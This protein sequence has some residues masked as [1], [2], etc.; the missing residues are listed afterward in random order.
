[1][2]V[3]KMERLYTLLHRVSRQTRRQGILA[4]DLSF[5]TTGAGL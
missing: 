3:R 2:F 1:M 5:L 4:E